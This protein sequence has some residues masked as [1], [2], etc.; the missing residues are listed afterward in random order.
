MSSFKGSY[1]YA[2]DEKG[3][4]NLPAKLRKYVSPEANDTFVITRGFE[5]CLFI[6]PV[7]EWNKLEGNLRNLS[8]YDPEHRRFIRT[9]LELASESQ[10]DGQARLSI[11]QE[12]REY[13]NIQDQVRVIGTLDKI[14]LWNPN[15]YDEYKNGQPESY[16][17]IAARVMK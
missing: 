3:R 12:L 16:E 4:V 6:Y 9:L 11:P 5:K 17:S 8:S 14:E 7:D 15:I 10:L 2:V 13:A 1:M